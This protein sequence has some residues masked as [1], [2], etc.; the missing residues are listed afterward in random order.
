M[1]LI[2]MRHAEREKLSG[3]P[4]HEQLLTSVG[5]ENVRLVCRKLRAHDTRDRINAIFSS[6]WRPARDTAILAS[7]E[8]LFNGPVVETGALAQ[9]SF[10]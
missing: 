7:N 3:L 10:K 8:L 4:E 6:P 2:L 5:K 1:K 9:S